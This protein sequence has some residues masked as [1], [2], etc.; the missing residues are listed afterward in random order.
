M[1][2]EHT[3]SQKVVEAGV[4][5]LPSLGSNSSPQLRQLTTKIVHF[6]CFTFCSPGNPVLAARVICPRLAA[7]N[8]SSYCLG[9]STKVSYF[10]INKTFMCWNKMSGDTLYNSPSSSASSPLPHI[11]KH[12]P[13]TQ[14]SHPLSGFDPK[15]T[16]TILLSSI[17]MASSC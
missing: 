14:F 5:C 10:F 17:P 1:A 11:Q 7:E 13:R 6:Q 4:W 16:G 3:C 2:L 12:C 8:T 15:P 9:T